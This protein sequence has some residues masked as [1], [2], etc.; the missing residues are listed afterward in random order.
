VRHILFLVLI[1]VSGCA[2][3]GAAD[4]GDAYEL[5]QRHGMLAADESDRLAARCG[6]SFDK[7]RY[8]DGYSDGFSRRGKVW[9][10]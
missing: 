2:G 5:G 4:C 1:A 7:A 3:M 9:S 8:S 6:A 10:L